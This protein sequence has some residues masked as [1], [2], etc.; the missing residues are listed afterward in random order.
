MVSERNKS[1]LDI[2]ALQQRLR[3][4]AAARDWDQ[5][6]SPKNLAMALAAESG[7][8][9]ELFQWLTEAQS[10]QLSEEERTDVAVE[11]ADIQIYLVRIADALDVSLP[12]AVEEKLRE[13]AQKYPVDLSKG[14]ATKY[15]RRGSD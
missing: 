5:F 11:L 8:L 7:E 15:S 13:N 10:S 1:S 3:D 6:H 2:A 14:N 12:E 4:F 9:L